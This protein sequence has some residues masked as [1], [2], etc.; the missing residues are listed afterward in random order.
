MANAL[1][2]AL[3]AAIVPLTSLAAPVKLGVI[4]SIT[5]PE[6]PIG[7]D[8]SNGIKLALEDLKAGRV[9]G[10]I[11]LDFEALTA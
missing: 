1:K 11:V 2:L 8:I 5:G 4:N 7:E 6:A 3:I 9:L 10:R